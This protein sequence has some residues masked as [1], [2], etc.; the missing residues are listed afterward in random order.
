[1][2]AI[3]F[4][5]ERNSYDFVAH[6][7]NIPKAN[8]SK[9]PEKG[10]RSLSAEVGSGNITFASGELTNEFLNLV[11]TRQILSVDNY[12]DRK[13]FEEEK[14]DVSQK[15]R[16]LTGVRLPSVNKNKDEFRE[17]SNLKIVPKKM[18]VYMVDFGTP[19]GAEF[20]HPHPAI[21]YDS[22]ADGLYNVI[23]CSTK[24]RDGKEVLELALSD[25]RVL[26][27]ADKYF[28]Q[29]YRG[30]ISY[31]LFREKQPVSI[32]RFTR[33][34]GRIDET[35]FEQIE[36][37]YERSKLQNVDEP[38]TIEDLN[39]TEKQLQML[40]NKKEEIIEIGNSSATYEEKVQ[41]ILI[42]FGFYP[43]VNEDDS[44]IAEAIRKSKVINDIE[45]KQLTR[46]IARGKIISAD[47]IS[48]KLNGAIK[49]R[50]K[51]L[52]PCTE[53]FIKLVNKIAYYR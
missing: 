51:E 48:Q 11:G 18:E 6:I 16:V 7:L 23:P 4:A 3:T 8:E 29:K 9:V 14:Y 38:F 37:C 52:Y 21:V 30:Q 12:T 42:K 50:F 22:P 13:N 19:L 1:M 33:F 44:Y 28:S 45:M 20:G 49:K 10:L 27:D 36:R 24:Y 34:L 41:K 46:D 2:I 32:S 26:K 25:P 35:Y 31:A 53:A 47:V 39:L 15:H 17:K 43:E 40:E 5:D